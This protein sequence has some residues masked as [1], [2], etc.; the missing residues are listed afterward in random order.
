[1]REKRI[2]LTKNIKPATSAMCI[3]EI[4]S[5]CAIPDALIVS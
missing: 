5:K 1:M 3:P 2:L 4:A